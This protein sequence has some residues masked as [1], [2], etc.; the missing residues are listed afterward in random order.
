MHHIPSELHYTSTHEWVRLEDNNEVVIGITHHAQR[1]LRDMV[2]VELPE[3][4]RVLI[5]GDDAAVVE[6]VKAAT[7]VF[8][9]VSGEILAVNEELEAT[10]EQINDDPYGA[11]WLFRLRMTEPDQLD[12]LMA[13]DEYMELVRNELAQAVDQVT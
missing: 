7:D 13:A 2:F 3:V 8:S 11:G 9:P 5:E 12:G 10:P 1:L 6:S 4:G